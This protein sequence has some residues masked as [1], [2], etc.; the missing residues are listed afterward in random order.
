MKVYDLIEQAIDVPFMDVPNITS[1]ILDYIQT[2]I[3]QLDYLVVYNRDGGEHHPN[4]WEY[5]EIKFILKACILAS[6]EEEAYEL[7]ISHLNT[8]ALEHRF[9][10]WEYDEND[11]CIYKPKHLITKEDF[12]GNL[13]KNEYKRYFTPPKV[14]HIF[15]ELRCLGMG[16][17]HRFLIDIYDNYEYKHNKGVTQN[18]R[19]WEYN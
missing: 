10:D 8:V 13:T 17:K 19:G 15:T 4:L 7:F 11:K 3:Y 9:Y 2:N 5:E 12:M 1:I 16:R 18:D 6:N 14:H